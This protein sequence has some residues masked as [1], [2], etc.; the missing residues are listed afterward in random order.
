MLGFVKHALKCIWPFPGAIGHK[1]VLRGL[2]NRSH[3]DS[4]LLGI[5]RLEPRMMLADFGNITN[6][7]TL[8]VL[9]DVKIEYVDF[10]DIGELVPVAGFH[11][12]TVDRP[13]VVFAKLSDVQGINPFDALIVASI[14]I[15]TIVDNEIVGGFGSKVEYFDTPT[16]QFV[17]TVT[18]SPGEYFVQ[19]VG[20]RNVDRYDVV[21]HADTATDLAF[22][23]GTLS[24]EF[25]GRDLNTLS[26]ASG[27]DITEY[28]GGCN[29]L[30]SLEY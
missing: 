16:N 27:A 4:Y 5:G 25:G 10:R 6:P 8:R 12:F 11:K 28:V 13:A 3:E 20:E 17:E 24:A 15:K 14:S 26:T 9:N 7:S 21:I 29:S 22:T 1:K 30:I 19:V 18:L 23:N 2:R